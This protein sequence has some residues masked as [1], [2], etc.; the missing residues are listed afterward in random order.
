MPGCI[1]CAHVECARAGRA[2][3]DVAMSCSSCCVSAAPPPRCSCCRHGGNCSRY[4]W[5]I[6]ACLCPARRAHPSGLPPDCAIRARDSFS[7]VLVVVTELASLCLRHLQRLANAAVHSGRVEV[8]VGRCGRRPLADVETKL[9]LDLLSALALSSPVA[10]DAVWFHVSLAVG[11]S[12]SHGAT[13]HTLTRS[14]PTPNSPSS[15]S[16]HT[17]SRSRVEADSDLPREGGWVGGRG[18]ECALRPIAEVLTG[19]K[20]DGSLPRASAA[21]LRV[22]I[23]QLQ[24][25]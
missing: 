3:G 10:G 18:L 4:S 17:Q 1:L 24:H 7:F 8:A 15:S 2:G 6:T 16:Q 23:S 13:G 5:P 14:G 12:P 19:A 25:R 22:L 9:C 20:G 21:H 11:C